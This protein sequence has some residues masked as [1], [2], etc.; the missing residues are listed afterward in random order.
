MCP[1][2]GN[3]EYDPSDYE[4]EGPCPECGAS[5][6]GFSRIVIRAGSPHNPDDSL[7]QRPGTTLEEAAQAWIF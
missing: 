7:W 6:T 4:A 5:V 3:P 2:C 1:C